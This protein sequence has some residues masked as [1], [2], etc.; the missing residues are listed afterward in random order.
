[1]TIKI[2]GNRFSAMAT[3]WQANAIIGRGQNK[4]G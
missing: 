4:I 1:M 2:A 3:E